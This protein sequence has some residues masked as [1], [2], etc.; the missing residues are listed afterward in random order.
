M[1]R[2][3]NQPRRY[4]YAAVSRN[5]NKNRRSVA[6][7]NTV[8]FLVLVLSML[9]GA[10]ETGRWKVVAV[11]IGSIIVQASLRELL[12]GVFGAIVAVIVTVI[13]VG[14][15]LVSWCEI[16]RPLARKVLG[17]YFG[18]SMVLSVF[19]AMLTEQMI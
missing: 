17:A 6:S 14:T 10:E 9:M 2:S 16:E 8:I 5:K 11:A 1:L 18:C 7:L 3:R 19:S 13:F 4:G 15:A 12:P